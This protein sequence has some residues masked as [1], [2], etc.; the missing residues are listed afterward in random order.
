MIHVGTCSWNDRSIASGGF[1]PASAKSAEDRLRYYAS[2]FDTVEIDSTFYAIPSPQNAHLW[3][4]RTPDRFVFHA[5]AY[6]CLTGHA[7]NPKTMPS[8]LRERLSAEERQADRV[9]VKDEGMVR[10]AAA[11]FLDSLSPLARAGKLGLIIFQFP[12]WFR[13]STENCRRIV[14]CRRMMEGHPVGVEFRHGS[15]L[16][17]ERREDVFRFLRDE[18]LT[19]VV[20]DEPQYGTEATAPFVPAVTSEIAYFRFHGRN[21][22]TWLKAGA[23]TS[24]RYDYLYSDEELAGFVPALLECASAAKEVFAMFNNCHAGKA[25]VNSRRLRDLLRQ[26]QAPVAEVFATDDGT[27]WR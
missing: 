4:E 21:A 7:I 17:Q 27:L 20:C 19:Y 11:I 24:D 6:G 14:A 9:F 1:Y 5:K 25:M 23:G 8:V 22:Q 18:G 12:P 16:R 10:D 13:Y 3:R 26:H 2:V 15:W